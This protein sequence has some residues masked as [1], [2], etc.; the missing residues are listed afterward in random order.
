MRQWAVHVAALSAAIHRDCI[1]LVLSLRLGGGIGK[2]HSLFSNF[3]K[4]LSQISLALTRH[5]AQLVES[6][7]RIQEALVWLSSSYIPPTHPM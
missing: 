1:Q 4:K 6:L 3:L 5:V 2:F 7:S